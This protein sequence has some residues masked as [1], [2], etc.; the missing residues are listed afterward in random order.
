M[1]NILSATVPTSWWE[2]PEG[3]DQSQQDHVHYSHGIVDEE[4]VVC[5]I[6]DCMMVL[7][8]FD[9]RFESKHRG[10]HC[11]AC[12]RT[13]CRNHDPRPQGSSFCRGCSRDAYTI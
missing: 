7:V 10:F 6:P 5:P 13:W 3:R 8:C 2:T 4:L 9:C 1:V 11:P 12:K